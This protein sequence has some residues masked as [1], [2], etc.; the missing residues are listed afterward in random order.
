MPSLPIVSQWFAKRRSLANGITSAG[1]GIGG[2]TMSFAIQAMIERIGIGWALR[3]TGIVGGAVLLPATMVLRTRDHFIMPRRKAFDLVL[4][5]RY[6]VFLMLCWAF[7][8]MFGYITLTYSLSDYGLSIGLSSARAS[9]QT[10][11]MN[12]GIAIGRPLTGLAS[13]R[14][15]R[16]EV[17]GVMTFM[18]GIFCF[19]FWIPAKGFGSLAAFSICAGSILGI[20]W[21][22]LGPVATEVVGLKDLPSALSLAWMAIVLPTTCEYTPWWAHHATNL[23]LMF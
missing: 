7:I 18:T 11:F 16:I 2:L 14:F 9:Y 17:P 10:A 4:F 15:G 22:A 23:I 5:R 12:L 21:P 8:M 3:I 13:D 1:S 6:D 20:F 19:A